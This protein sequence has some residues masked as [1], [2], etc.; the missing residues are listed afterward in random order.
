M[1]KGKCKIQ[2]DQNKIALDLNLYTLT[3]AQLQAVYKHSVYKLSRTLNY[4]SLYYTEVLLSFLHQP[5]RVFL[6]YM[7]QEQSD[8]P[9]AKTHQNTINR[10]E[11]LYNSN[12][13]WLKR[14][15]VHY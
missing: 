11:W 15:C 14:V 13:A 7:M 12:S 5:T 2:F 4:S 6:S 10:Q 1:I 9:I 3:F 8:Q